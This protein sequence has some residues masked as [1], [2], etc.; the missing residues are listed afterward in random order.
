MA[1]SPKLD[2]V[3]YEICDFGYVMHFN[4]G[5][6]AVID[7]ASYPLVSQH[8]WSLG[9]RDAYVTA[10]ASRKHG[11]VPKSIRL[12]RLLLGCGLNDNLFVDHINGDTT[13]NR[14]CNL[15]KV[16]A[17]QN[18]CNCAASRTRTH[19]SSFKGVEKKSN[20]TFSATLR[21]TE[22]GFVTELEAAEAYNRMAIA[23]QGEYARLNVIPPHSQSAAE[24]P[25]RA[26]RST[27]IPSG[28]TAQVG[29]KQ[30]ASFPED[31]IAWTHARA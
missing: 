16:T 18:R 2:S 25:D 6:S 24:S 1:N 9:H 20:G 10:N 11:T 22:N 8:R 21:L 28:S 5:R 17:S 30:D 14:M 23:H 4:D 13:D 29:W 31:D 12:P 3:I 26:K 7:A 19:N 27:A 15:R